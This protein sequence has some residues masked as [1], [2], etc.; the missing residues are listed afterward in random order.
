[1]LLRLL[2]RRELALLRQAVQ[3]GQV[4]LL[5]AREA[6]AS[7]QPE[8]VIRKR[9]KRLQFGFNVGWQGWQIRN[10]SQYNIFHNVGDRTVLASCG[11]AQ[12]LV[13]SGGKFKGNYC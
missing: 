12:L 3:S 1:M 7:Y 13:G 6:A 10:L 9:P 11:Q 4:D 8:H 5:L 2:F